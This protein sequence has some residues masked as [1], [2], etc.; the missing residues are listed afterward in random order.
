MKVLNS[1]LKVFKNIKLLS[2]IFNNWLNDLLGAKPLMY[3]TVES[4][5][6]FFLAL[7]SNFIV[8]DVKSWR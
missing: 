8:S 3:K 2:E 7:S 5:C 4:Y 1:E 6:I